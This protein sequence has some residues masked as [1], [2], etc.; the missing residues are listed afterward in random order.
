M[1]EPFYRDFRDQAELDAEYDVERSVG[2]FAPY[3]RL[4]ATTS[5]QALSK[6]KPHLAI[7]YGP[8]RS[9]HLDV[10]PASQ[11]QAP[12]LIYFHGGYWRMLSSA[13]FAFAA[14][15]P[16]ASGMTVVNVNYA[17]CPHVSMDEIVRQARAA[18]AWTYKSIA[19]YGGDAGR[20]FVGGH[21]AGAHLAA[22]CLLTRWP[23]AYGLPDDMIRGGILVGGLYDLR[24]LPFT[25]VQPQLQLDLA[26]AMR[27][28]PL[29]RLRLVSTGPILIAYGEHETRE[30]RRQ[31][32][33]F[34]SA[35][36]SCGN[37]AELL[38]QHGADHF[39]SVL[40]MAKPESVL[41]RAIDRFVRS[42]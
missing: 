17:L 32:E 11:S 26:Q 2:D 27:N 8:T 34:S 10:Y 24:P 14:L 7:P 38:V 9:E 18:V 28:S 30:F 3:R 13:E 4:F 40:Q 16:V 20:I 36:R 5:E 25:F 23:E 42:V 41:N 29:L 15:G 37:R 12:V 6:L 19:T 22:M 39:S 1:P 31:S 33:D 21:S 35:W